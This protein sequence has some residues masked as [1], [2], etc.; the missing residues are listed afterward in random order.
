MYCY[1]DFY[2]DKTPKKITA[3]KVLQIFEMFSEELGLS[4][5]RINYLLFNPDATGMGTTINKKYR[6][7]QNGKEKFLKEEI[8]PLI[9]GK[10]GDTSAPSIKAYTFKKNVFFPDT[11][12]L[13]FFPENN[14]PFKI[15]VIYKRK[16]GR[17][18]SFQKY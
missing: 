11:R 14:F 17:K 2:I 5:D 8:I 18:I 6:Y 9:T 7:N 1:L 3:H 16:D 10:Y 4:Y 15:S 13:I 12:V